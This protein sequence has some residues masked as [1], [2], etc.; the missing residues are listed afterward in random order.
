MR[1]SRWR[2]G[3]RSW[4][5]GEL[6][7]LLGDEKISAADFLELVEAGF[8]EI[9]LGT[10]P[11]QV[12]RI[13]AGDMVRTRLSEVKVLFFLGVNDGNIPQGSSKGG[14]ISDLDREFLQE[15][16]VL[17]G[18]G[19][20]LAPTPRQQMYI[21]RLY[22]YMNLTKPRDLLYVSYVKTA[23][24][25]GSLRPSYLIGLLRQMFPKA[26]VEIPEELPASMQL[27]SAADAGTYLA[28]AIREGARKGA[29]IPDN[30]RASCRRGNQKASGGGLSSLPPD[31][32]HRKDGRAVVS[33]EDTGLCYAAGNGG[34]VLSSPVPSVCAAASGERGVYL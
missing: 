29:G 8:E 30:L 2:S 6:Y 17:S 19:A 26:P 10:L 3:R 20:E 13:L 11:Q 22:L 18:S 34:A 23:E 32:D 7:D 1:E 15:T 28:G 25:G 31:P 16:N 12:D 21:Q 33:E 5:S 4:R 9:R 14:L 24:D 27:A